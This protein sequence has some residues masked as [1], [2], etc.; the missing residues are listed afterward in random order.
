MDPIALG[1]VA[2]A[3]MIFVALIGVP[4]FVSMGLVGIIGLIYTSG[5]NAAMGTIASLPYAV[6]A[7]Y[8]LAVVPLFFLMGAFVGEAEVTQ[9]AFNSAYKLIGKVRGG[10]AMATC[11]GSG[12]AAATMGSSVANAALF[13]RMAYPEMRKYG[14]D[15]SFSL[16]CIASSGTFAIMIPPSVAFVIYGIL[17]NESIGKLLIAGVLP[18][19]L[20]VVVYLAA[21]WT[22]AR[23]NP[24]LAPPPAVTFTGKEKI[25]ALFSLWSVAVLFLLV[26]GGIY[27]GIFTPTQAG[28]IGA[29]GALVIALMR[30]KITKKNLSSIAV[31]SIEGMSALSVVIL[32]GFVLMRFL[33]VCGFVDEIVGFVEKAH[34]SPV[35]VL[36]A[37]V[38]LYLILGALMDELS[39]T[40]CTIPFVYP[41]MM[42]LGYDGIWFGVVYT[43]LCQIGLIFPPVAMNLFV[44]AA[45]AGKD[46]SVLDVIKGIWPFIFLECVIVV[47]L[48]VFPDI[49]LFLPRL[50]YGR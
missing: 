15:K 20:T 41:I 17:T 21:I 22:M 26:V 3:L 12:L 43:K 32:G 42:K 13:T 30:K 40:V 7:N 24:K 50:M 29:F 16:G 1:V 47:I 4:I 44:V 48:C 28:A 35:G 38:I 33:V 6:F 8:G 14:Y 49:S 11:I 31:N 39:M 9:D 36:F 10:L 23:M 37:V 19:I 46:T 25:K 2:F 34:L 5:F 45:A 18:G 27:S